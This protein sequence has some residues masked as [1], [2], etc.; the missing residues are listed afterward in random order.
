MLKI[1]KYNVA[2]LALCL[3]SLYCQGQTD[4]SIFEYGF[5]S[6]QNFGPKEYKGHAQTWNIA[7]APSGLMYIGTSE[8]VLE[9]DGNNWRTIKLPN[10]TRV[11]ALATTPS[12]KVYC[13]GANDL[14]YLETND[15]VP[16]Y[17]ISLKN[18]LPDQLQDFDQ[19]HGIL[20]LDGKVFFQTYD[21]LMVWDISQQ[22]FEIHPASIRFNRL[23]KINDQIWIKSV[24]EGYR[25]Y[26]DGKLLNFDE[27]SDILKTQYSLILDW[28]GD[29]L[30]FLFKDKMSFFHN[31]QFLD[32]KT[33]IDS[34]FEGMDISDV[35]KLEKDKILLVSKKGLYF[36]SAQGEL[37]LHLDRNSGLADNNLKSA[38]VDREGA[39]WVSSNFGL[40]RIG[41][42][43]PIKKFD[44]KNGIFDTVNDI[45]KKDS[46]LYVSTHT[47][48]FQFD[49][50]KQ[51]SFENF[52]YPIG[53]SFALEI[54]NG[55]LWVSTITGVYKQTSSNNFQRV[56]NEIA[57]K[58]QQSVVD[59]NIIFVGTTEGLVVLKGNNYLTR[60]YKELMP[61]DI[62]YMNQDTV[63]IL[64][65]GT[66]NNKLV[67]LDFFNEG[68]LEEPDVRIFDHNDGLPVSHI[69]VNRV[70]EDIIFSS[71]FGVF[72][73]NGKNFAEST[74]FPPLRSIVYYIYPASE[75]SIYLLF[76]EPPFMKV[77][78]FQKDR[79]QFIP[80]DIPELSGI[81][82]PGIWVAY[83]DDEDRSLWFG[84]TDGVL[85]FQPNNF[86]RKK[87]QVFTNLNSVL[88]NSDSIIRGNIGAYN[89][90]KEQ[91]VVSKLGHEKNSVRFSFGLPSFDSN[92][93][94]KF[95]Y[96]L[97]GLDDTWSDWTDETTKEYIDLFEGSY[98]FEVIG[99]SVYGVEATPASFSFAISPPWYRMWWFITLV[100][101]VFSSIIFYTTRYFARRKLVLRVEEL[102]MQQ[103]LQQERERIS[104]DLHDH[105]GAQ[106]TSIISGLQITEEIEGFRTNDQMKGLI[107]S[108]KED[109]QTTM[110]SLRDSIWTL[111]N[112]SITVAKFVE[113]IEL[114]LESQLKYH[115]QLK[116]QVLFNG[117]KGLE[118]GPKKGLQL[119]RT[120]QEAIQNVVKHA[121]AKLITI[122][123]TTIKRGL[124]V[125]IKDDG[126]GFEN[127]KVNGEHYGLSNMKSRIEGIGGVLFINSKPEKG[128][129]IEITV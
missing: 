74:R 15:Q 98:T 115:E 66:N 71:E 9:F 119:I 36:I 26:K 24:G 5:P 29:S 129:E 11:R 80:K 106:L 32:F 23:Q 67:R 94:N 54:I 1:I 7:Q 34:S 73:F 123:I 120:I 122:D 51:N 105:V 83:E 56:S 88:V 109:A 35:L 117:H 104:S 63:G 47:G 103:K 102:E 90:S 40:S 28:Q 89:P 95:R 45:I 37:L 79:D 75:N 20:Y 25:I 42:H 112:E 4:K 43:L 77:L 84:M 126:K 78:P 31:N 82:S 18:K 49:I 50:K 21:H 62:R 118:I 93:S 128:T 60:S 10:R 8:G 46:I 16:S 3:L 85:N 59:P 55:Q 124:K 96:R 116:S 22:E 14:G 52:G 92:F 108:L 101:L 111:K 48:L 13:G 30:L 107:C 113:H 69:Q 99:K 53:E 58:F 12:G 61:H 125:S 100:L 38:F 19:I 72:E 17:F 68:T 6:I 91:S 2:I 57:Y 44:E 65:L 41:I 70:N 97:I 110:I 121:E 87:E 64:W 127:E 39:L 114:Y 81:E 86:Q 27:P 33:D 76:G